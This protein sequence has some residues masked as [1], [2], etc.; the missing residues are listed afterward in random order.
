[1]AVIKTDVITAA[2]FNTLQSRLANVLGNGF[3][4]SGY[5]Q[6]LSSATVPATTVITAAQMDNLRTD[7]N[8]ANV[9]Q[10][11]S[12]STLGDI[13]SKSI[14]GADA[15][16][17]DTNKGFNDYLN[18]VG[19]IE[20][21]KFLCDDTQ[22]SVE[23]AISSSRTTA[24]NGTITHSFTVSFSSGDARRHFFNSG[25]QIRFQAQLSGGSGSK[26]TNWA[27]ML[28]N[29]GTV[30]F[31]YNS[32]TATGSGTPSAIGNFQLT[33][34]YQV[35]FEKNGTSVYAENAYIIKAKEV[36]AN[37]IQ[38]AVEFQDNDLGEGLNPPGYVPIDENVTG[39][40][41]STI[42]QR[43]ASGSYVSVTSP[44]YTNTATL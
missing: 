25:G 29:M 32:T 7:I 27:T 18:A 16:G 22:A 10:T 6:A 21:N 35:V 33:T 9:H 24:W 1:M 3:A 41:T 12:L 44:S 31:A 40:I 15:I 13:S 30:S 14:I 37:Q 8:K 23:A 2:T 5:G 11:G 26:D 28:T 43:R 39:T 36:S 38:F 20:A 17:A 4:D 19:D 42:T 34:T